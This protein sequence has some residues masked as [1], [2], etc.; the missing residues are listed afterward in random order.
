VDEQVAPALWLVVATGA[1]A[2]LLSSIVGYVLLG[3]PL[4]KVKARHDLHVD[5][6]GQPHVQSFVKVANVR[7]RPVR[8]EQVAILT[9]QAMGQPRGWTFGMD[10]SEG[11]A[12]L[13]M[14]ERKEY[15]NA[16]P[17]MM[18][19]AGGVWPRRRWLRVRRRALRYAGIR[20]FLP[21]RG[22]PTKRQ[23]DK[24]VRTHQERRAEEQRRQGV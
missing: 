16:V 17:V 21:L 1:A 14:F 13:F 5:D 18:D 24:A 2:G 7:G 6:E 10:L 19:S 22:G 20:A 15:P 8:I 12:A 9:P 4:V 3:L 11:H 23:I